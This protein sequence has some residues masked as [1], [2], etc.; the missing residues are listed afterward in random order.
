MGRSHSVTDEKLESAREGSEVQHVVGSY[1]KC[2]GAAA[3]S[4]GPVRQ[5]GD[6]WKPAH[7][8]HGAV[9]TDEP[10]DNMLVAMGTFTG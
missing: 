1:V 10:G 7:E 6:G 5:V 2:L 4:K 9:A 8:A 3:S